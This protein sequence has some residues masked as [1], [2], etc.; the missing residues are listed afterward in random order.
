MA[1]G[2]LAMVDH[3]ASQYLFVFKYIRF[4]ICVLYLALTMIVS[5]DSYLLTPYSLLLTPN[6]GE[7]VEESYYIIRIF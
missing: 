2:A 1:K 5:H 3:A 7:K 4:M 6:G